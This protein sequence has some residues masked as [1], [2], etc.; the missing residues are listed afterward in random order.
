[1]ALKAQ[2][3][4]GKSVMALLHSTGLNR[5]IAAGKVPASLDTKMCMT[6]RITSRFHTSRP[7]NLKTLMTIFKQFGFETA[8]LNDVVAKK[9][10][11]TVQTLLHVAHLL[12]NKNGTTPIS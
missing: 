4:G 5:S 8:E 6:G 3:K 2:N 11:P 7:T 12:S 10:E 9:K 1:M